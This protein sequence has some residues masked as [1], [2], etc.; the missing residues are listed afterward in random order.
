MNDLDIT[1]THL[2]LVEDTEEFLELLLEELEIFGY[3]N[4]VIAHNPTEAKEKLD[5]HVFEVIIADMRLAGDSGGGF[6][7]FE[8]IQKRNITAA[9]IILTANDTVIDCRKA[10]K[11]GA[12]DYIPKSMFDGADPFNELHQSIQEAITYLNRWGNRK[13]EQWLANNSEYLQ[14]NYLDQYVAIINQNVMESAKTEEELKTKIHERK[15][16]LFL[17]IIEKIE[18]VDIEKLLQQEESDTLEFKESFYYDA[19]EEDNKNVG[20]RFNNLKTIAAFL[21]SEG[22]TLLI[23]IVDKDKSIYGIEN[24]FLISDKKQN[25]DGFELMLNNMISHYIGTEFSQFIK[26]SFVEIEDKQVCAMVVKK[27]NQVAFMKSL[28]KK[29]ND[30]LLFVRQGNRSIKLTNPEEIYNYCKMQKT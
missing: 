24:D 9:V 26:I 6:L 5:Q 18:I 7:V 14:E 13:D 30:K 20:L 3:K 17:P 1:N 8:E 27:S 12:W 25:Q 11:L 2:L 15:L 16:P 19:N 29:E 23:G 28:N 21:N 22:G 10:H 4:I